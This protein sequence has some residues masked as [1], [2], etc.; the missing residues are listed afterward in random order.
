MQIH[1]TLFVKELVNGKR[2]GIA[3]TKYRTKGICTRTQVPH[4]PQ[5]LER[6]TF[7]LQRVSLRI[8]STQQGNLLSLH[9][10]TLLLPRRSDQTPRNSNTSACCYVAQQRL[11]YFARIDY[12]LQHG[13]TRAIV[14]CK[15]H[16]I[17][18]PTFGTNPTFYRMLLPSNSVL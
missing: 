2:H 17:L 14:E 7:L 16:H 9:F 3:Q 12:N 18:I 5:E 6:M 10:H 8:C 11:F 15:K 4:F 1:K 13:S